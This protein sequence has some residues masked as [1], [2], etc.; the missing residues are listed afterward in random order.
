MFALDNFS[1]F[2]ERFGW[3]VTYQYVRAFCDHFG[4]DLRLAFREGGIT[5]EIDRKNEGLQDVLYQKEDGG[6]F[7]RLKSKKGSSTRGRFPAQST[8]LTS[9]WCS[10]VVKIDVLSRV[11]CQEYNGV[12]TLILTGERRQESKDGK[13]RALYAEAEKYRSYAKK[14]HA[15]HFRSVID[16]AEEEVWAIFERWGVQPH[17]CYMLGWNRASCMTCVFSS[18][19]IWAS[20]AE[21]EP[22]RIDWFANK[23]KALGFTLYA[24]QDIRTKVAAGTSIIHPGS[25]SDFWKAQSKSFTAPIIVKG[26]WKLPVGAFGEGECCGAN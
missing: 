25:E 9:R 14:R 15:I 2:Q 17:P 5:R 8:S 24:K 19:N 26:S 1:L 21:L 18:A 10:A 22:E 20:I 6:P 11:I 3:K 23:E 13:G 16:W 12:E 4:L 7:V